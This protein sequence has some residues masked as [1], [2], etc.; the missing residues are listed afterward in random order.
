[1]EDKAQELDLITQSTQKILL[2]AGKAIVRRNPLLKDHLEDLVQ[3]TYLEFLRNYP[4]LQNHPNIPGWLV[5]TLRR[6]AMDKAKRLCKEY[7]RSY[8]PIDEDQTFET[9][10]VDPSETPEEAYIHREDAEKLHQTITQELG[11]EAYSILK[12]HYVDG[13]PIAVLADRHGTT[14]DAFKMRLYRWRGKL[15]EKVEKIFY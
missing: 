11:E 9:F 2:Q 7:D 15:R 8:I 1:M 10:V 13:V 12:E 6:K 14:A 4:R 5:E 3:E